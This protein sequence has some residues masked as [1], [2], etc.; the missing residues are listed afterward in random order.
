MRYTIGDAKEL[1]YNPIQMESLENLSTMLTGKYNIF[2][3][4]RAHPENIA[5]GEIGAT[6][7]DGYAKP[8]TIDEDGGYILRVSDDEQVIVDMLHLGVYCLA[9]PSLTADGIA[10]YN[11]EFAEQA[12]AVIHNDTILGMPVPIEVIIAAVRLCA[13][14][15]GVL[16]HR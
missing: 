13:F 9:H 16:T 1:A 12:H 10:G 2:C 6:E 3:T 7:N 8:L 15:H 4:D 11:R 5:V 14:N